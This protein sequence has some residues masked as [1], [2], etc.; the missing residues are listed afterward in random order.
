M[1]RHAHTHGISALEHNHL[2][3]CSV[4]DS[5]SWSHISTRTTDRNYLNSFY[6]S[7][8]N[9]RWEG[10][11]GKKK[12]KP[13]T[14]IAILFALHA[15]VKTRMVITKLFALHTNAIKS[16]LRVLCLRI[17]GKKYKL[18]ILIFV[19]EKLKPEQTICPK[20]IYIWRFLNCNWQ[21]KELH[22]TLPNKNVLSKFFPKF[23][24]YMS[25]TVIFE[26]GC[27]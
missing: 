23:F 19:I 4:K 2:L 10:K 12:E 5:L 21:P 27:K 13:R 17:C 18:S 15:N 7:V 16:Q 24:F 26:K 1:T 14:S 6:Q 11:K 8:Q 25:T 22:F 3:V 20:S 9:Q